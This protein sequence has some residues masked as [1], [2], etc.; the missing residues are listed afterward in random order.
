MRRSSARLADTTV[1]LAELSFP[2]RRVHIQRTRLTFIHLDNLLHFA[3]MDR[4]GRVD[5]FIAA[6]LPDEVTLLLLKGGEPATAVAF[7]VAGREVVSIGTALTRMRRET[8]RGELIYA[9]APLEQLAWMY[10]SCALPAAPRSVD[11]RAPDALVEAL[12]QEQ[13]SG[14]LEL[15]AD[16]HVSYLQFDRGQFV[17][18]Y[19]GNAPD[20]TGLADYVAH[21]C[22][23]AGRSLPPAVAAAVFPPADDLPAQAT[24]ALIRTYRELFWAIADAAERAVPDDGRKRARRL[25]EAFSGIHRSLAVL[26]TVLDRDAPDLVATPEELTR[27]LSDWALQLL[28]ELEVVA[29]GVAGAV[30]KEATREHRFMLQRAGFYDRLPWPV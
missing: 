24:P 20:G 23:A 14:V 15:I 29:P 12:R 4:D 25:G 8:E 30:L 21:L 6:Y 16:G 5:G 9:D 28:E 3:K 11:P 1:R 17:R 27:A 7:T 26:N 10:Q 18:G 2:Q 19:F 22:A 13:F